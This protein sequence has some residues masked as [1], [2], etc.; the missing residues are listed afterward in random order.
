MEFRRVLVRSHGGAAPPGLESEGHLRSPRPVA[1]DP[2][3]QAPA[4]RPEARGFS[5]ERG[6]VGGAV[7]RGRG[8][9]IQRVLMCGSGMLTIAT[10]L[11]GCCGLRG[12]PPRPQSMLIEQ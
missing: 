9:L 2:L 7:A 10:W 8:C 5:G 6:G 3:R 12:T 4:P 1:Q 11:R